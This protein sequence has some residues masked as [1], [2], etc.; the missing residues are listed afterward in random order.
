M[1]LK[2]FTSVL[3]KTVNHQSSSESA[4]NHQSSAE[5]AENRQSIPEPAVQNIQVV[6]MTHKY[7]V[8]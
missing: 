8:N 3:T 7:Q 4:A 5:P 1:L 6:A 2:A